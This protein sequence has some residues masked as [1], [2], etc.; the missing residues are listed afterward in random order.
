MDTGSYMQNQMDDQITAGIMLQDEIIADAIEIYKTK[1]LTPSELLEMNN[2]LL[3]E[4]RVTCI[5]S[6]T[7]SIDE[8]LQSLRNQLEHLNS[9]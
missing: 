1:R 9:I 2:E 8:K 7:P 5:G 3:E 4:V 6:W